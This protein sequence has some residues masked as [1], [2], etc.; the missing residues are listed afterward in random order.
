MTVVL[1]DG[2]YYSIDISQ[3]SI[4]YSRASRI[5]KLRVPNRYGDQKQAFGSESYEVKVQGTWTGPVNGDRYWSG[6]DQRPT[7]FNWQLNNTPVQLQLT[8]PDSGEDINNRWF[9]ISS[10]NPELVQGI[11]TSIMITYSFDLTEAI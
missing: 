10:F 3:S 9:L 6:S 2:T 4:K 5:G 11:P 1:Y 8:T 7:M